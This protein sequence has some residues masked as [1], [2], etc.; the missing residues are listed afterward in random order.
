MNNQKKLI[1]AMILVS[2]AVLGIA[3]ARG[4]SS[5]DPLISKDYLEGEFMLDLQTDIASQIDSHYSEIYTEKE[6]RLDAAW[7]NAEESDSLWYTVSNLTTDSYSLGDT[8]YLQTGS[9]ILVSE[10]YVSLAS[11][12]LIDST[13]ATMVYGDNLTLNHRYI[14]SESGTA[15]LNILSDTAKVALMGEVR[16]EIGSGAA[17]PFSDI[18]TSDW[19]YEAVQYVYSAGLFNG[20]TD[21]T[22]SPYGGVTRGM[23]ATVLYRLA[24]SPSV[25]GSYGFSDVDSA[26]WYSLGISWASE[27]GVVTGMGDGTFSPDGMVT[28]EQMALMLYR[29][30][31]E[32]LALNSEATGELSSFPDSGDISS[33]ASEG[34]SW[35]VGAG[36]LNGDTEGNLNPLGYATRAETAIMLNRLVDFIG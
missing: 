17:T 2:S 15:T 11:G 14:V 20:V 34:L 28:R 29:Y 9:T 23:L 19:Y 35:A 5:S 8:L 33:W 7:G 26:M 3:M 16:G 36:I 6:G 22:F 4:G 30:V 21:T 32:V 10:G 1:I 12:S 31:N 25:S 18:C 24:D 13:S 27:V